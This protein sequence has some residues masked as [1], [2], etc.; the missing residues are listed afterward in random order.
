[1]CV[2][3]R[4]IRLAILDKR[5]SKGQE[6]ICSLTKRHERHMFLDRKPMMKIL[7]SAMGSLIVPRDQLMEDLQSP[8]LCSRATEGFRME[9][10]KMVEDLLASA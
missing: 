7:Q 6:Q 3:L 10:R 9:T 4:G 8:L 5:L 2:S 1:M